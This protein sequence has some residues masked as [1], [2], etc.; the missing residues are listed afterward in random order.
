MSRTERRRTAY[1]ESGHAVIA[2]LLGL[3]FRHITIVPSGIFLGQVVMPPVRRSTARVSHLQI[4]RVILMRLAGGIA[5]GL[6]RR[7]G[8][9][10]GVSEDLNVA[11]SLMRCLPGCRSMTGFTRRY[12]DMF[13]QAK[14]LVERNWPAIRLT[15]ELVLNA[16]TLDERHVRR[17]CE[18]LLREASFCR[19]TL[20]G[21]SFQ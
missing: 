10:S 1:H 19:A 8:Q 12:R 5:E 11:L 15:A 17:I 18:T 4:R 6:A 3:R 7:D 13:K 14:D 2:W 21:L 20:E 9:A 16:S